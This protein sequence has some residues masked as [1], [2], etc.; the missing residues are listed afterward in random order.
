M[1]DC[2]IIHQ[3]KNGALYVW[4]SRAENIELPR[5]PDSQIIA[6]YKGP[7]SGEVLRGMETFIQNN[8]GGWLPALS[9]K[10]IADLLE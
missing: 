2:Y 6:I 3:N 10:E 5:D 8:R 9:K 1:T 7:W 4:H